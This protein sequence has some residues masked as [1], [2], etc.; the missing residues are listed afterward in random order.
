MFTV[1]LVLTY[2]PVYDR[3][4]VLL[5][6]LTLSNAIMEVCV[7]KMLLKDG[8]RKALTLSYDDGVIYDRRLIEILDKN[9]IKGTFNINTCFYRGENG[10][11]NERR[12]SR[13]EAISLYKNSSHEVAVHG[14]THPRLEKLDVTGVI[15]EIIRDREELEKDFDVIIRGMAYP[16]GT[17]NDSVIDTLK[18]C[19]IAYSRTVKSTGTFEFPADWYQ[20]HPTCHHNSEQLFEMLQ[21]FLEPRPSWAECQLF[22]LWGHSYEFNDKNNWDII[23]KFAEIA[24]GHD[25]I[26]YATNIEIYDYV[27]AYE[28]LRISFD[29]KIIYNPTVTDVWVNANGKDFCIKSGETVRL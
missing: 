12:L 3:V 23:E 17:Y 24:G 25:Y 22:Y 14:Y 26:W 15:Y 28:S 4:P 21:K 13:E 29:R 9:G 2:F 27:K 6:L 8:K 20:W 16:Y 19:G 11:N 7:M 18:E 1:A 10:C 5:E